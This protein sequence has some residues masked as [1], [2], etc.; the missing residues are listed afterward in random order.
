MPTTAISLATT[1]E[2][3]KPPDLVEVIAGFAIFEGVAREALAWL[4]DRSTYHLWPEGEDLY[5]VGTPVDSMDTIVRGRYR[6]IMARNG[7]VRELGEYGTGY[8]T[9]VLPFSRMTTTTASLRM[10]EDTYVM[11]TPRACFTEM[12]VVSYPLVQKLVAAMST[13]IREFSDIRA[14]D[15]KMMSLG[16]LSAGLAHE[17]N[18]PSAA[19]VRSA[20]ELHAEL[21]NTPESFKAIMTMRI[22]PAEVD[23]VNAILFARVGAM[24]A[25]DEDRTAMRRLEDAEALEDWL[26]DH[27]LALDPDDVEAFA[28]ARFTADDLQRVYDIVEGRSMAG[29]LGWIAKNIT[30]ETLT[31]EIRDAA[32]RI[33]ELVGSVKSYT[34]MDRDAGR[35]ALDLHEGLRST[36]VMLKHRFK[37]QGVTL[38]KDFADGLPRVRVW[39]GQVNQV[40][41]NLIDNAIDAAGEGGR[42][43]VRT[44]LREGRADQ[45][46]VEVEDDGP[47]VPEELRE[48]I[49]EPFFTTKDVGKGTGMG[50][51]IAQ[52]ILARHGS[53]LELDSAPG[54][55]VFRFCLGVEGGMREDER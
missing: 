39:G 6:V 29:L 24:G 53:H 38:V 43:T 30:L 44:S 26:D 25:G 13:R 37:Q 1:Y 18:N 32:A 52:K 27:D 3:P 23:A 28:A 42:V 11:R 46:C 4:V 14:Q 8:V 7:R 5:A 19:I 21:H 36:L 17:L 34:H 51:D 2:L 16:K 40:Y 54:R 45:V 47:G 41:T 9:G 20:E 31:A 49:F 50:L 22:T 33:S 35:E 10:L 15:E 48:R 12:V 55:T